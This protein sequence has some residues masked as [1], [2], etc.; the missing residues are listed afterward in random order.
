ME[1]PP[2]QLLI[3]MAEAQEAMAEQQIQNMTTMLGLL[4]QYG[5]QIATV[6]RM[7]MDMAT[8]PSNSAHDD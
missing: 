6:K 8:P 3:I 2:K 1:L 4:E 5:T 7:V